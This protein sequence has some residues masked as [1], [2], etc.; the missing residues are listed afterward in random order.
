MTGPNGQARELRLWG[1]K[2]RLTADGRTRIVHVLP[3][4]DLREDVDAGDSCWCQPRVERQDVERP[5]GE[6][7]LR[8]VVTHQAL[9]GRELVERHGVN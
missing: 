2:A 4:R 3:V 9:D 5:N 8:V 6:L 7:Q 1:W